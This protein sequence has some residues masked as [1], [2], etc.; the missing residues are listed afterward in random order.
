M[1]IDRHIFLLQARKIESYVDVIRV[2]VALHVHPVC[3]H[4]LVVSG[5][6]ELDKCL[7]WPEGVCVLDSGK[8]PCV[9]S[10]VKEAF[11]GRSAGKRVVEHIMGE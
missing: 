1:H 2:I 10:V 4:E 11:K 6:V 8:R 9:E 7:P 5:S 3:R